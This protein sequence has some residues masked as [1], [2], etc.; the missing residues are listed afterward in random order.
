MVVNSELMVG[1]EGCKV[2]LFF[3]GLNGLNGFCCGGFL[4]GEVA[5][6]GC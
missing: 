3:N 4:W 6:V 2:M 5:W 1:A